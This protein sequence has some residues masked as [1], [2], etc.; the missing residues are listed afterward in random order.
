MITQETRLAELI[1]EI[2]A[3]I[4]ELEKD[5]LIDRVKKTALIRENRRFLVLCKY[6]S[7]KTP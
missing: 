1:K 6:K 2:E 5:K 3:R 7:I 4:A